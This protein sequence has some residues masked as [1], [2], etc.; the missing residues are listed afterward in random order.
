MI[1]VAIPWS[2]CFCLFVPEGLA[3]WLCSK[4]PVQDRLKAQPIHRPNPHPVCV[5]AN[6]YASKSKEANKILS[7]C[8]AS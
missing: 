5:C 3:V 7:S 1:A 6:S 4:L 2:C 8:Q